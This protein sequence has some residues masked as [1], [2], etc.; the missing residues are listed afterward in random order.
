MPQR[1]G[2][3]TRALGTKAPDQK[4]GCPS[5]NDPT[6]AP[7]DAVG[8]PTAHSSAVAATIAPARRRSR[9]A[10]KLGGETALVIGPAV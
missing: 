5:V 4:A 9:I 6:T 7:A 3:L 1:L 8:T 10:G 2:S